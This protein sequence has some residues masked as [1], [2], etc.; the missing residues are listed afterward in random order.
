M[1]YGVLDLLAAASYLFLF[2]WVIPSRSAVITTIIVAL[3]V[4][5]GLGGVGMLWNNRWGK[6]VATFASLAMLAGCLIFIVLIIGSIAYLHGIYDGV[7]QA[8][9]AIGVIAIFLSFEILGLL[10]AL[11]L[12]HLRRVARAV[13]EGG[14]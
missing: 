2:I 9:V 5:F 14:R 7:G 11:Q 13:R 10:P 6:L 4:L 3:S 8:G 12:A 1:I